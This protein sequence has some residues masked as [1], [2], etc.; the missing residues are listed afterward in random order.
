MSKLCRAISGNGDPCPCFRF[1]SVVSN[2]P[3]KIILL[4]PAV[5]QAGQEE[6]RNSVE[7]STQIKL[8]PAKTLEFWSDLPIVSKT[9][10]KAPPVILLGHGSRSPKAGVALSSI[11]A[12]IA[13]STGW[14]VVHACME[15]SPPTLESVVGGLV[16]KG[17][18]RITVMPFFLFQGIHVE[19]DIPQML[20]LITDEHPDLQVVFTEN[21]GIDQ[22][23]AEIAVDRIKSAL[24]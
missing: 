4:A 11:A 1:S 8:T 5:Q 23:L 9:T 7:N 15:L 3:S 16:A 2:T 12:M 10:P 22:R 17:H 19:K 21:L 13:E 18:R 24:A 14:E 6:F 20:S